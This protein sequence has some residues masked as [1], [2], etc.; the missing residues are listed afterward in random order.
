MG[1]S[2]NWFGRG[3]KGNGNSIPATILSDK[4]GYGIPSEIYHAVCIVSRDKNG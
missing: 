4:L 1:P 3:K 2:R